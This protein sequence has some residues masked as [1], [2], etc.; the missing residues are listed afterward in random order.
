MSRDGRRRRVVRNQIGQAI[1]VR[2]K[3]I[4]G[5]Q[6]ANKVS[7][8]FQSALI[9]NLMVR[10]PKITLAAIMR[11]RRGEV[12]NIERKNRHWS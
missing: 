12:K 1:A 3:L 2:V 10:I 7:L 5:L 4:R 9:S 11:M 8:L 6:S